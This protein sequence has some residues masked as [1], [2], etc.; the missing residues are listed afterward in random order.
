MLQTGCSSRLGSAGNPR[1][2]SESRISGV[3][4]VDCHATSLPYWPRIERTVPLLVNSKH[5]AQNS[6]S[7]NSLF[8]TNDLQDLTC[9]T[10]SQLPKIWWSSYFIGG[11]RCQFS[12]RLVRI[13]RLPALMRVSGWRRPRQGARGSGRKDKAPA[14]RSSTQLEPTAARKLGKLGSESF[15]IYFCPTPTSCCL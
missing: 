9:S 7:L 5:S 4:N 14:D 8:L 15:S 12:P 1:K 6:T 2:V 11:N 13:V 10:I 3:R